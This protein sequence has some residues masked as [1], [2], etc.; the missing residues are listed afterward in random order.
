MS[1]SFVVMMEGPRMIRMLGCSLL[2]CGRFCK[3]GEYLDVASF[4][5]SDN[6]LI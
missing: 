5:C 3:F 2:F 4:K 6:Q 1:L